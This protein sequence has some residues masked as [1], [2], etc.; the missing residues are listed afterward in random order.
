ML[1]ELSDIRDLSKLE[2]GTLQLYPEEFKICLM[3][4]NVINILKEDGEQLPLIVLNNLENIGTMYADLTRIRQCLTNLFTN[5]IRLARQRT[6]T[7]EVYRHIYNGKEWITFQVNLP[8]INLTNTQM[9]QLLQA[10]T[11]DTTY[12]MSATPEIIKMS[13]Q[14]TITKKL[15]ELMGGSFKIENQSEIGATFTMELPAK[16]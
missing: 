6:I 1:E 14:L 15:C 5:A 11:H 3:V 9:Q 12:D 7:L 4:E 13:R 8:E 10:T 16:A 2:L